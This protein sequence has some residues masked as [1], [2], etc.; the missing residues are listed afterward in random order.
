LVLEACAAC[1]AWFVGAS[2]YFVI[3]W[4]LVLCLRALS[5][6]FCGGLVLSLCCLM[7]FGSACCLA[8][9]NFSFFLGSEGHGQGGLGG[10]D[11]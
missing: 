7:L 6:C 9:V 8:P 3:V 1:L 5:C 10:H 11:V 2:F 4:A